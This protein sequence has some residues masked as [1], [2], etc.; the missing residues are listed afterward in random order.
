MRSEE[1]LLIG[2]G[3]M[4]VD[5]WHVLHALGRDVLTIGRSEAAAQSFRDKTGAACVAGGIEAYL[6]GVDVIPASA[7]VAVGVEQLARVARLLLDRGVRRLLL[8][9]PGALTE[10]ELAALTRRAAELDAEVFIAYNRR[11]YASTVA[12]R[13]LIAE[14]GGVR[15]IAFEF[16]EWSHVIEGIPKAEGVKSRWLIGNSTHV[17]DLAFHLAGAPSEMCNFTA[18]GLAWHPAASV[19]AGAGR[20]E[21]GALFS[22]QANWASPGRWGVEVMLPTRRLIFRPLEALQ[23]V[24]IGGVATTTLEIDDGVDKQFKPGLY[25]QVEAFL[26]RRDDLLCPL[27]EQLRNWAFYKRIAGY[28]EE[29]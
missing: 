18:G 4:A 26:A 19:F 16:T 7:I 17:I 20:T 8:E 22:Y 12:A 21:Q 1:I 15:S 28:P 24:P 6:E 14:E 10:G 13:D 3:P 2:S 23:V 29:V 5:Y 11:F 25:R 27:T 9:K